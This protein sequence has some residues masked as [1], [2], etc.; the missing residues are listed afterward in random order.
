LDSPEADV[1]NCPGYRSRLAVG[2]K[3][4]K[5]GSDSERRWML[6]YDPLNTAQSIVFRKTY[7][8]CALV[9]E[10]ILT[11]LPSTFSTALISMRS[12]LPSLIDG[13]RL[14]RLRQR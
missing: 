6:T 12:S 8:S 7:C 14:H 11:A 4:G 10:C 9:G 13:K 3:A 2:Y 1:F 5:V